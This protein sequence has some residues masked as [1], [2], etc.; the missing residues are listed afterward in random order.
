MSFVLRS[1]VNSN[2]ALIDGYG[3]TSSAVRTM[4]DVLTFTKADLTLAC[5]E[6]LGLSVYECERRY[7]A[8]QWAS[9]ILPEGDFFFSEH[10]YRDSLDAHCNVESKLIEYIVNNGDAVLKSEEALAQE[11]AMVG[12]II[13]RRVDELKE[14]S[15]KAGSFAFGALDDGFENSV[16]DLL[17]SEA[18]ILDGCLTKIKSLFDE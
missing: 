2:Q 1:D 16:F 3:F 18:F 5:G 17:Q 7:K 15:R 14:K 8:A 4:N 6:V 9:F 10:E 12:F 13:D 11:F